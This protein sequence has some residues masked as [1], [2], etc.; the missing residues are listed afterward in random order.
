M[1]NKRF[2][3][4]PVWA[5]ISAVIII[6]GIVLMA[7]LGFNYGLDHPQSKTF[8]VY[9]NVVVDLSEEGKTSLKNYCDTAFAAQGISYDD[10]AELEGQTAP[11]S[12][13]Q[14]AF[15]TTGN[16]F[17]LRYTF[18]ADVSDEALAATKA[19]VEA[20]IG[21]D[22]ALALPA[23]T[24]VSFDTLSMQ[25]MNEA[26]WRGAV[27]VAVAAIVALIYIAIR[28]GMGCAITG[29]V[30]CINDAFLT[31]SILA[32]ARIPVYTFA[33]MLYAAIAAVVSVAYWLIRCMKL[34]DDSKEPSA[35]A[36]SA[37]ESVANAVKATDKLVWLVALLALAVVAVCAVCTFMTGAVLVFAEALIPVAVGLYSS[38][39]LAPALHVPVKAH[40]DKLKK[41]H[42][43][44]EGKKKASKADA[45]A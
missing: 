9:Y 44:Y 16:D 22:E 14:G 7:L 15:S 12:L 43:R 26:T 35:G 17:L 27:A 2:K 19:A 41:K 6:A 38:M 34:R 25:P 29:L 5:A 10:L 39:L 13:S 42:A 36:L 4:L 40:F 21:G 33:P 37:Q 45:E 30:A 31:L 28:F 18:S 8:D 24:Y 32:I 23:Q 11:V 1:N 20:S 3:L